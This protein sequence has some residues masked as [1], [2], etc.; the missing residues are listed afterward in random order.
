MNSI[1][2]S[3]LMMDIFNT[4]YLEHPL[5]NNTNSF[6]T[7]SSTLSASNDL[8]LHQQD[9]MNFDFNNNH[10]QQ[11]YTPTSE[12]NSDPF[13]TQHPPLIPSR[14]NQ[15]RHSVA[16]G[17]DLFQQQFSHHQPIIQEEQQPS[18]PHPLSAVDHRASM[19]NIFQNTRPGSLS[20][21]EPSTDDHNLIHFNPLPWSTSLT[22][23]NNT[24]KTNGRHKRFFSQQYDPSQQ[25]SLCPLPMSG[26]ASRRVSMATPNDIST[27]NKMVKNNE[28]ETAPFPLLKEEESQP[29]ETKKR[30]RT[31]KEEASPQIKEE[32][33]EEEQH[34]DDYP[35]ITEADVEAAKKNPNAI[36]RRQKLRYDGD[37]Y[38]PKWVRYTGQLKE[39]YCDT[40]PSG[41]WLQLKNSAYWYHKQFFHGI[42]SVSGKR[43][44]NPLEQRHGEH[45]ALE[46][47]CHQCKEYVPICNSKRKSSV[48]WYRHAHK[49]HIYDRPKPRIG[50][51]TS[52][53]ESVQEQGSK[54]TKFSIN[55]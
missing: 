28:K 21:K 50:G 37:E 32:E 5:S 43:F 53:R 8:N 29:E 54:K 20:V 9:L 48:L 24:E 26:V 1:D 34:P 51:G 55:D 16:V 18:E 44:Q 13:F 42:S 7:P 3:T 52:R 39:G 19:P 33:E 23:T 11:P 14:M 4:Q 47:L 25:P 6:P 10:Q 31:R 22:T 46:G 12:I 35:N 40:C 15:R 27:W 2:T 45:D 36:P 49:C 38:T 30:K 17:V 41:K